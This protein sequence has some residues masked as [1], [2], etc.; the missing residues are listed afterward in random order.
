MR[1]SGGCV[2]RLG[3]YAPRLAVPPRLLGVAGLLLAACAKGG[4]AGPLIADSDVA[5]PEIT[6][7]DSIVLNESAEAPLGGFTSFWGF[8]PSGKIFVSDITGQR[9]ASFSGSGES[10]ADLGR[11]G[12]GPGEFRLPASIYSLES[13]GLVAILDLNRGRLILFREEGGEFVREVAVPFQHAGASTVLVNDTL[14]LAPHLGME[15]IVRWAPS[16]DSLSTAGARSDRFVP[17]SE[18]FAAAN[19]VPGLAR[20]DSLVALWEPAYGLSVLTVSGVRVREIPVPVA[21]RVGEGADRVAQA[22]QGGGRPETVAFSSAVGIGNDAEG[23]LILA[24]V[25]AD[26]I[27]TPGQGGRPTNIRLWLTVFD[28]QK[29][30]FCVDGQ[31]PLES[32]VPFLVLFR[33]GS[34][35]ILARRVLPDGSVRSTVFKLSLDLSTCDWV[36]SAL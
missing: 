6:V 22:M 14:L 26:R 32:D 13:L 23:R 10:L 12:D 33:D 9:V 3:R 27:G 1:A 17:G 15:P 21:R 11:P 4:E 2:L 7:A 24:S 8:G 35:W 25:D 31:V 29:A 34:P 36:A 30:R 18:S 28:H 16:T 19:G 5:G 20:M